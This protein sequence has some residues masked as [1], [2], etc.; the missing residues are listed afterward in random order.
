MLEADDARE[1][2]AFFSD[3]EAI[4][5]FPAS[6]AE[7][8]AERARQWIDKQLNRYAEQKFGLQALIDKETNEFI[9]Q[10]GLL[11]QEIDGITETEVGYHIFKKYWGRGF[12][13]EAARMFISYAFQNSLA[14]SVIS[15]IDRRNL[16]S[17]RVA[18]KNGLLW[19]KET[20]WA[21][22]SVYVY[23][24][25]KNSWDSQPG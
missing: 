19:E 21:G 14:T 22:L 25:N 15:I 5:F 20:S 13:P 9:G 17:L 7:S 3:R 10:C 6:T 8:N 23:R 2:S 18:D 24:I 11:T 12:A 4:Q 1:W 16:R